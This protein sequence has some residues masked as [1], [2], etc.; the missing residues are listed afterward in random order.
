MNRIEDEFVRRT[1]KSSALA[2]RAERAMPGGDTRSTAHHLPYSLTITRG[3]GPFL[4]DVDGNRY[5][6]VLGNYTSLVHGNSYPP[7]IEAIR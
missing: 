1:P 4:F 6:D 7:I 5:L 2:K 3:E